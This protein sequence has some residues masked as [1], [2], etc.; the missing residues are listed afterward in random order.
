MTLL[1]ASSGLWH[2]PSLSAADWWTIA[3]A[4]AC[5]SACGIIGCFLVLRR[6]SMLGDAISHAIL[7]GL[8]M[9]FILSGTRGVFPMLAGAVVDQD[10]L[11]RA[12][13]RCHIA[14]AA[15]DVLA[16]EPPLADDP[17]LKFDNVFVLPHIASGTVETR[18]A[19][20]E[21]AVRNLIAC[22]HGEPCD[23]LVQ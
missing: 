4:V 9:G 2:A 7:P 16:Q 17:I 12:L 22:L 10:A 19:M 20:A 15:L 11:C 6:M 1:A 13:E 21:L 8:A 3:V 23:C 14:G 5:A 18:R